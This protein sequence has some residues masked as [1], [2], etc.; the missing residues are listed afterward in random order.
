MEEIGDRG[1]RTVIGVVFK[2]FKVYGRKE[3]QL[4]GIHL[5]AS[6]FLLDT[7]QNFL[8]TQGGLP[9]WLSY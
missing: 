9:G 4:T 2:D 6:S 5:V 7:S 1:L 8:I 3:I